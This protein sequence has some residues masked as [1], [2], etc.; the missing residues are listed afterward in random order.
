MTKIEVLPLEK[1]KK[2]PI[3]YEN[4]LKFNI[5]G[6]LVETL[7]GII[8]TEDNEHGY[9]LVFEKSGIVNPE[10]AKP[11]LRSF[12]T[13]ITKIEHNNNTFVPLKELFYALDD[14]TIID[15]DPQHEYDIKFKDCPYE[16]AIDDGWNSVFNIQVPDFKIGFSFGRYNHGFCLLII[17]EDGSYIQETIHDQESLY[18]LLY[19]WHFNF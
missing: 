9:N 6:N 4:G 19:Q 5:R 15:I 13:I 12:K 7:Q 8:A 14:L 17:Y 16:L 11:I 18:N 10:I 2:Y 3:G 1:L